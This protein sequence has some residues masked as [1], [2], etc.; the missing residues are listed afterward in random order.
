MNLVLSGQ[1]YREVGI[2]PVTNA[3]I[4]PGVAGVATFLM[5]YFVAGWLAAPEP[6]TLVAAFLVFALLYAISI[7]RFGGI[8]SEEVMLVNSIEERFGI[9]LEPIKRIGRRLMPCAIVAKRRG[10]CRVLL[11]NPGRRD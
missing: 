9:D 11:A 5:V 1:L 6:A 10:V 4:R 7:L 8:E 2:V 3:M